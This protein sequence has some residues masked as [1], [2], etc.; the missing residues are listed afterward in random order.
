MIR[1]SNRHKIHGIQTLCINIVD[2]CPVGAEMPRLFLEESRDITV[3]V[4]DED[5]ESHLNLVRQFIWNFLVLSHQTHAFSPGKNGKMGS[6]ITCI[7]WR[8]A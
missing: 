4:V 3:Y 1:N 6:H 5:S 8:G 7:G 2:D